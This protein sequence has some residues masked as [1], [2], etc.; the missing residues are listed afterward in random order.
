MTGAEPAASV[1]DWEGARRYAAEN[2][3]LRVGDLLLAPAAVVV[4]LPLAARVSVD[5]DGLGELRF[6]LE[7]P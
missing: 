4:D 6:A 5:V 7:S 1:F 2:T 3:K